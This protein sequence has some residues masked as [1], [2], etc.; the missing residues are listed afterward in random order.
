MQG[1]S[2][3]HPVLVFLFFVV[4]VF[5]SEEFL[6]H[7]PCWFMYFFLYL[8]MFYQGNF[9]YTPHAAFTF[10]QGVCLTHPCCLHF[11]AGSFSYTYQA[12]FIF[13]WG[14]SLT[15]PTEASFYAGS[16]SYTSR[17]DAFF[18][19]RSFAYTS[20]A[21]GLVAYVGICRAVAKNL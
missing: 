5:L 12:A 10:V 1:V 6:L 20:S 15:H 21:V 16:F 4:V 19:V 11:C 17:A 9:S 8:F 2:L 3:T 7:I 13:I 18:Y 14:I